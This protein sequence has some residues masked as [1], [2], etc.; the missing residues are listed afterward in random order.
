M[1]Q[2]PEKYS[3]TFKFNGEV[4]KK[5][6]ADIVKA[7]E[8]VRPPLLHTDMYVTLKKGK[9]VIERKLNLVQARKLFADAL[10]REVFLNNLMLERYG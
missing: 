9:H 3:L 2:T 1:T 7:I 5:R 10:T 4:K 8:E 6:T